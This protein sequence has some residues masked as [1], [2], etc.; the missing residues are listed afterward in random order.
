[1][2]VFLVLYCR[3]GC[4]TIVWEAMQSDAQIVIDTVGS[5]IDN[6]ETIRLDKVMLNA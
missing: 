3:I 1:M 5:C 4:Q 2:R 6:D